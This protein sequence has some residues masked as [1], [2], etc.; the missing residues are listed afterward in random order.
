MQQ[1]KLTVIGI[2]LF[3]IGVILLVISVL[4]MGDYDKTQLVMN[5]MGF[6]II[7]LLV[8]FILLLLSATEKLK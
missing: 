1:S 5:S 2:I 6:G 4:S 3:V 8:G 7:F